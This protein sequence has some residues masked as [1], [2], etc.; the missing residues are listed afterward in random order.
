[1][2]RQ[3]R[4]KLGALVKG[5][6][7]GTI[8]LL[9]LLAAAAG[10]GYFVIAP[11][12]AEDELKSRLAKLEQSDVAV[13]T[14]EVTPDGLSGVIIKDFVLGQP[15]GSGEDLVRVE[16]LKV[17]LD[18]TALLAGDKVISSVSADGVTIT[19][20]R[21]AEGQLNLDTVRQKLRALSKDKDDTANEASSESGSPSFLRYFGGTWPRLDVTR[22]EIALESEGE[23]FPV[24]SLSM[25]SVTLAPT[26][27]VADF[28]TVVT[29]TPT[30]SRDK[31]ILPTEINATGQLALPL[32]AS[33]LSLG[34]DQ[35]LRASGIGP[36]PFLTFGVGDVEIAEGATI[37]VA[38]VSIGAQFGQ[39][40]DTIFEAAGVELTLAELTPHIRSLEPVAVKVSEPTVRIR[41]NKTGGSNIDDLRHAVAPSA[42]GHV[43]ASARALAEKIAAANATDGASPAGE[44]KAPAKKSTPGARIER[45]LAGLD[46][47]K[48]DQWVPERVEVTDANVL[49]YDLR[50]TK[51]ARPARYLHMQDAA[52]TMT[53][54]A[55]AGA[56]TLAASMS[57]KTGEDGDQDRGDVKLDVS[58]NYKTSMIKISGKSRALDI[59][60]LAQL[61]GPRVWDKLRGGLLDASVEAN[62]AA[63]GKP[64]EFEGDVLVRDIDLF[65]ARIAEEPM[66]HFTLGYDF[67]GTFDP[68]APIPEA[69]LLKVALDANAQ[70]A[71][72]PRKKSSKRKLTEHP[73]ERGALIFSR[74]K[75]T[76]G[77]VTADFR[78]AI[79][80]IDASKPLP[81]RLDLRIIMEQTP[82][83]RVLDAL[84]D[85]LLGELVGTKLA[86]K[87]KMDFHA[88][89][90]L[91]VADKMVWKGEPEFSED[92][93][94]IT[95]PHEVDV[96]KLTD[97]FT[98]T[99]TDDSVLFERTVEIPSM[100]LTPTDW[101]MD[102][103]GLTIE[104]VDDHWRR[105]DSF[106]PPYD[107]E[108]SLAD[109]PRYWLSQHVKWQAPPT[110][111]AERDDPS[112]TNAYRG[113]RKGQTEPMVSSPYGRYVYVP[114]AH[115][116]PWVVRAILTTE[117]NSFFKHD[118]FNRLAIRES[119]ERNLANGEYV[120]GASTISMQLVKNL[121]LTRKK[122]MARKI[123]EAILVWLIESEVK[124]PKARMME[125]YL[126]IIE[127][128][129]GVFGIHDASVHYFGK[130]PNELT[131]AECAWLVTI[132]P[133]PK[134]QHYHYQR[135]EMSDRYFDRIKRYMRIMLSRERITQ[136]E[137]DQ[138]AAV[139]PEF[140]KQTDRSAPAL[141]PNVEESTKPSLDLLF[142]DLFDDESP[143]P[144]AGN[145]P[146]AIDLDWE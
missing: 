35:P 4:S 48:V 61:G 14:G 102:N 126:N 83:Q 110:P 87:V 100:T 39:D 106:S 56:V 12:M 113:W 140:Y 71:E 37:K 36:Y 128:G 141:R 145:Q 139:K 8:L 134:R 112:I 101:L 72:E 124:V 20:K 97:T 68:K 76:M 49:V 146:R 95:M 122:V 131:L 54:D 104:Q 22:V 43:A 117:D 6:V 38:D 2:S 13:S 47:T 52:L 55:S 84:P 31:I 64:I 127:F 69:K 24:E 66:Q 29:L 115:I 42:P 11:K 53:H 125:L 78:P 121:F 133:G 81:A 85:A 132:V 86:G 123:Q 3:S 17:E 67:A 30:A 63:R 99:I 70:S 7:I 90:P 18:R 32:S 41:Y 119:I 80:G 73:P 51:V 143:T 103:A 62:Q 58:A 98:H 135:G 34:F 5:M 129:P 116:S 40:P 108:P 19:I 91:Y 89:V 16:H 144:P 114:L 94:I 138:A 120:R 96:R 136:E 107:M 10:V 82:V 118:G 25:P 75:A 88:E 130:R 77:E 33:T 46:I 23:P 26:G 60:W 27:D 57:A 137:Y 50:A 142:P 9:F 28:S 1:M 79:Y 21:D 105:S 93:A 59:S 15:D 45:L 92:L 109:S 111:W 74:G 44:D 65:V